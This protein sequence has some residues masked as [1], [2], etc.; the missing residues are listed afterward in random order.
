M[1]EMKEWTLMFYFAGDNPLAPGIVAQLKSLKNAGYHPEANVVAYFDPQPAGTP[2]HIFDVNGILKL[3]YPDKDDIGFASND[4]FVRN[5]IEDRLW[6]NETSRKGKPIREMVKQ[7][8]ERRHKNYTYSLPPLTKELAEAEHGENSGSGP[9]KSLRS[10]INFCADAY[11]AKHYM[12]FIL[13][14]GLVV[15]D[16]VFLFDEHAAEHSVTLI[17]LG[18]ALAEFKGRIPKGSEFELVSFHSC[19]MSSLEVAFQLQGTANYMLA[20]QGPA[21][22]GSWPYRQILIRVF[23]DLKDNLKD[24][25]EIDVKVMLRKI[26]DYVYYNSTDYLLAGYSFDLCLFDLNESKVTAI[27]EPIYDLSKAL[28]DGLK[29]VENPLVSYSILLAHWKSQSQWQENYT[30]LCDFCFCLYGYCEDFIKA[31]NAP[32]P[33]EKIR[34]ACKRVMDVL[35]EPDSEHSDNPIILAKFAGPDS[36][37]SHGLS[38]FFPWTRPTADRKIMKK[39]KDGKT[40]YECYRFNQT[41]WFDFLNQYWGPQELN[42]PVAG[43]TMRASRK[44][45]ADKAKYDPREESTEDD[46]LFEDIASLMF[47]AA[48]PL[49]VN[50]ALNDSGKVNPQDPTGDECTCGSIKNYLR[51]TRKRRER[52]ERANPTFSAKQNRTLFGD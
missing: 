39:D 43:S 6:G 27:A 18:D 13:G 20:S 48:G 7:Q 50:G 42:K 24:H 21:F 41:G 52:G 15:G 3:K 44:D 11:P 47:N 9:E 19:S 12:L 28:I 35:M 46:N 31:V 37:Y 4:T 29:N 5:L 2:A 51:D 14:H 45:E 8:F 32:S 25:T 22:V 36:Q 16:D 10:F 33:Y 26:F 23:N 38:V 49:N 34:A 40:E 17:Q 1:A 30:D